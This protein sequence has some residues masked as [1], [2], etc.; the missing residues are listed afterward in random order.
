MICRLVTFPSNAGPAAV[1]A[2]RLPA[3][4]VPD[5]EEVG[6]R[7]AARVR[8]VAAGVDLAAGHGDGG[9]ARRSRS[10]TVDELTALQLLPFHFAMRSASAIAARV[11][12]LAADVERTR[13]HRQR[14]GDEVQRVGPGRAPVP[15]VVPA[16]GAGG[17]RQRG[18]AR[19]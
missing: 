19:R 2:E 14:G 7:V 17:Q 4:A 10:A 9:D 11:G 18:D 5:R 13:R 6:V 12:E 15:E 3:R 8:E 16:A 1:R